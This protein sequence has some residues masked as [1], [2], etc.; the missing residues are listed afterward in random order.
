MEDV[1][2]V[3]PAAGLQVIPVFQASLRCTECV[4]GSGNNSPEIGNKPCSKGD[5]CSSELIVCFAG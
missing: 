1:M 3:A 2:G 5:Q 4:A